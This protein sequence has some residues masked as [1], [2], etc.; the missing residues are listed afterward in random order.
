MQYQHMYITTAVLPLTFCSALVFC[1]LARH[2][3]KE[4]P[5][6]SSQSSDASLHDDALQAAI[7]ASSAALQA[8]FE[9]RMREEKAQ[10]GE[11]L[12]AALREERVQA[13]E[14]MREALAAAL[15][16][17][18][19]Y[20]VGRAEERAVQHGESLGRLKDKVSG[21]EVLVVDLQS[22]HDAMKVRLDRKQA[23]MRS[24]TDDKFRLLREVGELELQQVMSS[25]F[26]CGSL[27]FLQ[28]LA[29]ILMLVVAAYMTSGVLVS[30][31]CC[32]VP[33]IALI[34]CNLILLN[35][36]SLLFFHSGPVPP[37]L[38]APM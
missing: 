5:K 26:I 4:S 2:S 33:L 13:D 23:E 20:A 27:L 38:V 32:F 18:R 28:P 17:E 22:D 6:L 12:A 14:R 35:V 16:E 19:A 21:L 36:C 9:E 11:A 24:L 10:A 15:R 3:Q 25:A 31:I 29:A 34:P 30:V 8:R 7:S 1:L 37:Q